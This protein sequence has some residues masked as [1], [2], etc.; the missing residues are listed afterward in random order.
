MRV[1]L[2]LDDVV[3]GKLQFKA[4]AEKR[5]RKNYMELLLQNAAIGS[6][7]TVYDAPKLPITHSDEP[8]QWQETIQTQVPLDKVSQFLQNIAYADNKKE[9]EKYVAQAKRELSSD[10]K[11]FLSVQTYAAEI[12]EKKGFVY[13]DIN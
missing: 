6:T 12:M 3:L 8:K 1:I 9:I 7:P 11:S 5:S 13:N 4:D 2:D 10:W